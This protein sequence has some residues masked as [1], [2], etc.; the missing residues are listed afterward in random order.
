MIGGKTIKLHSFRNDNHY[1][2]DIYGVNSLSPSD[3]Y[4]R[5]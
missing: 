5:E 3:G 2:L 4:M 1:L